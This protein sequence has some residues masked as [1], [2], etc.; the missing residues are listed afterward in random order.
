M[1]TC[2]RCGARPENDF[3]YCEECGALLKAGVSDTEHKEKLEGLNKQ[4]TDAADK[5]LKNGIEIERLKKNLK[6]KDREIKNYITQI[7]AG[8][9][10]VEKTKS[11]RNGVIAAGIIALVIS[12]VAGGIHVAQVRENYYYRTAALERENNVLKNQIGSP[13]DHSEELR[14]MT[15]ERDNLQGQVNSLISRNN[16]LQNEYSNLQNQVD[17]LTNQNKSLQAEAEEL[18]HF[19]LALKINAISIGNHTKSG[20]TIDNYGVVLYA[21]RIRYLAVRI[22]YN[23]RITGSETFNVKIIRPSGTLDTG[24]SS[25]DGYSYSWNIYVN[26]G[27]NSSNLGGWGTDTGGAYSAG[28]YTVEVWHNTIC[29]GSTQVT[30][31]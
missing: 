19:A 23:S 6:E 7:N 28:T 25:P 31:Y 5:N 29:L 8:K 16:T 1:T 13:E 18:R 24:S 4:L 2:P 27:V 12:I 20:E 30:L 15:E 17:S 11:Q 9:N 22:T 14:S 3:L 26:K 21:K 10:N